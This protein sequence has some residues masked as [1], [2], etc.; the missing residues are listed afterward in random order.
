[1]AAPKLRQDERP[2]ATSTAGDD[3]DSK[4]STSGIVYRQVS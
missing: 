4:P 1:M 2:P 3:D